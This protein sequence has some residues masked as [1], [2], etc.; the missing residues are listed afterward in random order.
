MSK[1]IPLFTFIPVIEAKYPG[2]TADIKTKIQN[3]FD[4]ASNIGQIIANAI[5]ELLRVTGDNA[6]IVKEIIRDLIKNVK[7]ELKSNA[8]SKRSVDFD[9]LKNKLKERT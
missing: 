3:I 1:I 6:D 7:D 9:D 2:L 8:V 5:S 4:K